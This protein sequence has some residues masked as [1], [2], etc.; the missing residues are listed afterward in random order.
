MMK[1][2]PSPTGMP[3]ILTA[4]FGTY[5]PD[6]GLAAAEEAGA[7]QAWKKTVGTTKPPALVRL[8]A[9]SGLS[10]RGGA[11]YPTGA[12]WRAAAEEPAD[13]RYVVAN[14]FEA[15]PG[16]RVD[17]T[18][19]ETDPHAVVEGVALAAYA[20]GARRAYIALRDRSTLARQRLETVV[21]LAEEQ[22]Y[23]GS[24]AP[25]SG[26]DIHGE[27]VAL[28]GGMVVGEETVLIRAIENKR[29]QPEQRP[30]YPSQTGL[31]GRPTVV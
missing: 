16:A 22:G 21:R 6:G 8:V 18:L 14:G 9:D 20:V 17:R 23:I 27:V 25:G 12:K 31:Y 4:R 28:P 5:E 11:A 3:T 26:V 2:L 24:H 15:D 10:G 1:I 7:W 13:E 29:A 19:M 30:P